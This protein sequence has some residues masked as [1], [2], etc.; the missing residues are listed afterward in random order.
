MK[1]RNRTTE[2]IPAYAMSYLINGDDSGLLEEDI[3]IIDKWYEQI[4]KVMLPEGSN[5]TT[6][7]I[8]N[9]ISEESSFTWHPAF[10]LACEVI[11]TD[12][13]IMISD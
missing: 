1:I 10:G 3:K 6:S 9:P 13:N 4:I 7:I 12:I 11:E 2:L 8:I 5:P